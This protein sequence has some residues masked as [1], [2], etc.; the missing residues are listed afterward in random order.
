MNLGFHIMK[1]E[2]LLVKRNELIPFFS[3]AGVVRQ[4]FGSS[5]PHSGS[6]AVVI[7]TL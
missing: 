6:I 3:I 2:N 1:P 7:T 5:R 4:A